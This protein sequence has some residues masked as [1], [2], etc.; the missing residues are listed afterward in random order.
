MDHGLI[1]RTTGGSA[2]A[3][4]DDD[5][6]MDDIIMGRGDDPAAATLS[7]SPDA[8]AASVSDDT[9][10]GA[11][12]PPM[13]IAAMDASASLITAGSRSLAVESGDVI[14]DPV[15]SLSAED[16]EDEWRDE[17]EALRCVEHHCER[18]D[19]LTKADWLLETTSME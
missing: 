12:A 3:D 9:G 15:Q 8:A 14:E 19:T 18:P 6:D 4:A 5:S 10:T 17:V 2:G 13:A 16:D 7:F 11:A 1:A